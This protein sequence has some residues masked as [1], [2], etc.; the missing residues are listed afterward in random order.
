[1]SPPR[2]GTLRLNAAELTERSILGVIGQ[3]WAPATTE[4]RSNLWHRYT[5]YCRQYELH[6]LDSIDWAATMFVEQQRG[7]TTASTRHQ[8]S[9][10]LSAIAARLGATTPIGRM[11]QA[12]LRAGGALE[13]TRQAQAITIDTLRLLEAAAAREE[14]G[15]R[16]VTLLFIMWKAA[17]RFDEVSR[18]SAN[19]IVDETDTRLVIWWGSKT[20]ATRSTPFRPDSFVVIEH[21]A[22]LPHHVRLAVRW[23]KAA[24]NR[25]LC[26]RTI[27]WFDRWMKR[28]LPPP[29]NDFSAHS[30]KA[31]A[32]SFLV[33][34]SVETDNSDWVMQ[35]LPRLAKHQVEGGLP[36]TT[37]GYIR[38]RLA[39]A[40]A[41]HTQRLTTLLPW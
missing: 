35:L 4:H 31:G 20:K 27:D 7:T 17:S 25:E 29:H 18:L 30:I 33:Q 13:P 9:K 22:G 2:P 1:M 39:T 26:T 16:L 15:F 19:Q 23:L 36:A 38:D 8:Y 3:M 6:P 14:E 21:P 41:L 11:Y 32:L 10:D 28:A 12:G 5:E 24:G 34:W 40:L 37:I